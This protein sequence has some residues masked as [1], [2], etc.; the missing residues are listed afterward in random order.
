[1]AQFAAAGQTFD[2]PGLSMPP[3]RGVAPV[4]AG[5]RIAAFATGFTPADV[6][7]YQAQMCGRSLAD[8]LAVAYAGRDAHAPQAALHYLSGAGLL[9][10]DSE[11]QASLWGRRE[12]AAPE[13]PHGG[14]AWP[15]MCW[16]T[17]TS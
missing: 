7:P 12:R 14:T 10:L 16:T 15:A 13:S 1:M 2:L 5:R 9:S 6:T 17:T 8:T 4:S 3:L 11:G